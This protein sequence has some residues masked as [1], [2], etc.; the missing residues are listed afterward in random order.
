MSEDDEVAF[1][2]VFGALLVAVIAGFS[3]AL[4]SWPLW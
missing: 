3:V 1:V 4:G 2:A